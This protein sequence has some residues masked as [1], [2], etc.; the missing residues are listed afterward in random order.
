MDKIFRVQV[1]IS[2]NQKEGKYKIKVNGYDVVKETVKTITFKKTDHL[3]VRMNKADMYAPTATLSNNTFSA[4]CHEMY[5][6]EEAIEET[7]NVLVDMLFEKF[8]ELEKTYKLALE[9]ISGEPDV[10]L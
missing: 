7:T 3:D 2:T 6:E 8:L 9:A 1:L 5:C 4:I 10:E